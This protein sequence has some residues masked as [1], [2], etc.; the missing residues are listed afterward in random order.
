MAK[1]LLLGEF[2][3][4][5][6]EF[7][8]APF[9]SWEQAHWLGGRPLQHRGAGSA[10]ASGGLLWPSTALE[11]WFLSLLLFAHR[12]AWAL[13]TSPLSIINVIFWSL[14]TWSFVLFLNRFRTQAGKQDI[15]TEILIESWGAPQRVLCSCW[16]YLFIY[17]FI[18]GCVGSLLLRAGFL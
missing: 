7:G 9:P 1:F 16:N 5:H 15:I 13:P 18:C 6:W 17:L 14:I 10:P 2:G 8:S 12:Y 4:E 3:R 11:W